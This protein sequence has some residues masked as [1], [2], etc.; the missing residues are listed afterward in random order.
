MKRWWI[1]PLALVFG[2][3]LSLIVYIVYLSF[4]NVPKETLTVFSQ[5]GL[6]VSA[7]G[8]IEEC[9]I[10]LTG[11]L[12]E[13]RLG[14]KPPFFYTQELAS[15]QGLFL[16]DQ[17]LIQKM[18]LGWYKGRGEYVTYIKNGTRFFVAR[19]LAF[20]VV[21]TPDGAGGMQVAAA[22]ANTLEEMQAMLLILGE[23]PWL[24]YICPSHCDQL[25]ER[26]E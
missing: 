6:I 26:L 15:Q 18:S 23:D 2:T 4:V 5:P 11:I 17:R 19:D 8:S 1:T 9:E 14:D 22:P 12:A 3:I 20:V 25:L 10:E 16:N 7:D 13:Y 24:R 21:L